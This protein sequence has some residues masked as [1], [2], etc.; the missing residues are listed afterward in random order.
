M[1]RK[2]ERGQR[3]TKEEER[4]RKRTKK[5]METKITEKGGEQILDLHSKEDIQLI[6]QRLTQESNSPS[7]SKNN[8]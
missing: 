7:K 4:E 8:N 3:E 2:S 6:H 5:E 1:R